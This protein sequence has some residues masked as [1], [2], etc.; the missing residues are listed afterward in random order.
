MLRDQILEVLQSNPAYGYRRVAI[1][2]G[3]NKKRVHR[4]MQKYKIRP[5]KRKVRLRKRRDLRREPMTY[6]NL[7]K[8]SFTIHKGVI[9]AAD[10]T[11]IPH[12]SKYYYLATFMDLYTREIIDCD[13]SNKHDKY[14]VLRALLN[15]ILN[16]NYTLPKIIHSDQGSEYCS[17][18]YLWFLSFFD[19]QVSM[20]KKSSPWE[21]GYQG[22]FYSNFKTDLGLEFDRFDTLGEFIEGIHQ[23]IH[24][25][26]NERIRTSLKMAPSVF[27]KGNK[28][29]QKWGS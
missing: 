10:F 29:V 12:K 4:V 22:S 28:S 6:Q 18:E 8:D 26:N 5:Y 20:S 27:A 2:L 9:Y 21:N 1:H 14:T 19:I 13:I 25:Y 3:I 11:Y 23:T 24:Y 16:T 15:A 17:K 7:I